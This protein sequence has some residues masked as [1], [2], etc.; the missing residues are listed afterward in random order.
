MDDIITYEYI[1]DP[2]SIPI[3]GVTKQEIVTSGYQEIQFNTNKTVTIKDHTVNNQGLI[4][5]LENL[6]MNINLNGLEVD[7]MTVKELNA[8]RI[9]LLTANNYIEVPQTND[10]IS[11]WFKSVEKLR[12]QDSTT[13]SINDNFWV[14]RTDTNKVGFTVASEPELQ[15]FYG[16]IQSRYSN[17][18]FKNVATQILK[19]PVNEANIAINASDI[20]D[21]EYAIT[22]TWPYSNPASI[23]ARLIALE[24]AGPSV[25]QDARDAIGWPYTHPSPLATRMFNQEEMM[26][27]NGSVGS[28]LKPLEY[29]TDDYLNR[30]SQ[31][32]YYLVDT[33]QPI[34]QATTIGFNNI[35]F[36]EGNAADNVS[37]NHGYI[38]NLNNAIPTN[39]INSTD[40]DVRVTA[41]ENA[42]GGGDD[43][44][45]RTYVGYPT[46]LSP[47]ETVVEFVQSNDTR[48]GV[49]E[50]NIA[51]NLS[52][53]NSLTSR[54][55][56]AETNITTNVSDISVLDTRVTTLEN[57]D[58]TL[59]DV[60]NA[61]STW[62]FS[63]TDLTNTTGGN[64]IDLASNKITL[65]D[66]TATYENTMQLGQSL[67]SDGITATTT[68][69]GQIEMLTASTPTLDRTYL[70][71]DG[72]SVRDTTGT[73]TDYGKTLEMADPAL[74]E[75]SYVRPNNIATLYSSTRFA[76]LFSSSLLSSVNVKYGTDKEIYGYADNDVTR[77]NLRS[78]TSGVCDLK[79]SL[80]ES[81]LYMN[82][83]TSPSH[84]IDLKTTTA[85]YLHIQDFSSRSV[86]GSGTLDLDYDADH[87][88]RLEVG[89]D[90]NLQF[91]NL[92]FG[93]YYNKGYISYT[94]SNGQLNFTGAHTCTVKDQDV[95]PFEL[96]QCVYLTGDVKNTK[97]D[98]PATGDLWDALPIVKSDGT[99]KEF[100]GFYLEYIDDN[101]IEY[102]Q[103]CFT[104]SV[105][106]DDERL[107]IGAHGN[108]YASVWSG[109]YNAGDI[110]I[111]NGPY[112]EKLTEDKFNSY[113]AYEFAHLPKIR[114]VETTVKQDGEKLAV[115]L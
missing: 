94:G 113:T 67:L 85:S 8:N 23:D 52:S 75:T 106:K 60:N 89:S 56:T 9:N 38:S 78:T 84:Y 91:S 1:Q 105:E 13:R 34:I 107:W 61:I 76:S 104:T 41:L 99:P 40:L 4:I 102:K 95:T 55:T 27:N 111:P 68:T 93:A 53:I 88:F 97:S 21:I 71:Y 6:T 11:T 46:D 7:Y 37:I 25:D 115:E 39:Y 20:S 77:L 98:K 81:Q 2:L 3:G 32:S 100:Y 63:S 110:L 22:T 92:F 45:L 69:P 90:Y 48:I 83:Y 26:V 12:I 108:C 42:S 36:R 18:W 57:T 109:S 30:M 86:L 62:E 80:T 15:F 17:T 96:G 64:I 103:G 28:I 114:C 58:I 49:N 29:R 14:E 5:D 31:T 87:G 79:A 73:F 66:T 101:K 19:V 54:M 50:G 70:T 33:S 65:T 24:S 47:F 16:G 51:V 112:L 59:A 43:T 10:A 74:T 35:T 72:L 82:A 44:V